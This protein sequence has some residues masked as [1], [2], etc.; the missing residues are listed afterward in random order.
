MFQ[1]N[2]FIIYI[3]MEVNFNHQAKQAIDKE[4][5]E[6]LISNEHTIGDGNDTNKSKKVR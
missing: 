1:N 3:D 5:T 4:T 6:I 2:P